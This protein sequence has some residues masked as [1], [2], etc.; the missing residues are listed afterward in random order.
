MLYLI[1]RNGVLMIILNLKLENVYSF[2]DNEF[3]FTYPRKVTGSAILEEHLNGF[4]NFRY[5]K[6]NILMGANATGKTKFGKIIFALHLFLANKSNSELF[7]SVTNKKVATIKLDYTMGE[8]LS[9]IELK[10]NKEEETIEYTLSEVKIGKNDAYETCVAKLKKVGDFD[11]ENIHEKIDT[12]WFFSFTNDDSTYLDKIKLDVLKEVLITFDSSIIAVTK[13]TEVQNTFIVEFSNEDQELIKDGIPT[14][15][16][17]FSAG[18]IEG[19]IIAEIISS[20]NKERLYFID[21]KLSYVHT[22]LEVAI[23]NKMIMNLTSNSQLFFTTHNTDIQDMGL[24]VHAYQFLKKENNI[25]YNIDPRT[26]YNKND[27]KLRNALMNDIFNIS[28]D[29]SRID[30]LGDDNE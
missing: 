9:R 3:N 11:L 5:R 4:I 24:P 21:E 13:S 12:G 19:I 27:R 2:N 16:E 28:P 22:E 25:V 14:N 29:T 15:K 7:D 10:I 8:K 20:I 17:R 6:A 30:Y 26:Q 23:L 18:T 1:Y